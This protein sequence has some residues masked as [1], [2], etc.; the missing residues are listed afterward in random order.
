MEYYIDRISCY[1]QDY[2]CTCT[3]SVDEGP[4]LH[5]ACKHNLV[6]MVESL[7]EK[8]DADIAMEK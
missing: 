8:S 7:L 1:I 4:L 2:S 3:C 6:N 5:Y